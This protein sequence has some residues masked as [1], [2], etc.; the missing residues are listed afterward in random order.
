MENKGNNAIDSQLGEV[1]IQ[2]GQLITF[3]SEKITDLP[4]NVYSNIKGATKNGGN[5]KGIKQ[6]IN[7]SEIKNLY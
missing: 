6:Y 5:Y 4:T 3:Y 1:I 2:K 7:W